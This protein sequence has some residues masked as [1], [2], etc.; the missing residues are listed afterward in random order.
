MTAELVFG[1]MCAFLIGYAIN[2]GGTCGVA[3][4]RDLVHH[5]R[6]DRFAGFAVASGAAGVV[7][8]PAV[9]V[10]GLDAHLGGMAAIA[11]PLIIGAVLL[12]LGTVL[13]DACLLGSLWRLG[14][15]EVHLLALP[16]GLA[17]GFAVAA[18]IPGI[19][20]SVVHTPLQH[21]GVP[22][23]T[24]IGVSGAI[25]I[26]ALLVLRR[27]PRRDPHRWP[28]AV[29]MTLLGVSGALLH[30]LQPGWSYADAVRRGVTPVTAMMMTGWGGAIAAML[31]VAGAATSAIRL[32]VFR[33]ARPRLTAVLRSLGGGVLIALGASMIPGGNDTLLLASVPAGSVSAA[34]AFTVMTVVVIATVAL[35][36]RL[37]PGGTRPTVD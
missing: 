11:P 25:L 4:A 28:M 37:D 7:C 5:R 18:A 15:G 22:E 26:A 13:N 12:G 35:L 20:P 17:L 31:T 1:W 29:A 27:L 10:L 21:L 32:K 36:K 3:A 2:Q 19:A 14:N 9:W 16:A 24:I 6:I 30:V 8:L 23:I 33:P 34:I